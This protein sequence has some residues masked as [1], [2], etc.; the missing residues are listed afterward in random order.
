MKRDREEERQPPHPPDKG[1]MGNEQAAQS[2]K[3]FLRE[4][5]RAARGLLDQ[6]SPQ[7]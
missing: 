6:R 4:L 5:K 7:K 2:R 3:G 1:V